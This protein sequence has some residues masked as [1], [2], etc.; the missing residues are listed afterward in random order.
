MKALVT[1]AAGF[2]GSQY[3][4]ALLSGSLPGPDDVRVTVLDKLAYS[5]NL[6]NL[7]ESRRVPATSSS[8]ATSATRA[9]STRSCLVM[10]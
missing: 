6:E 7:A 1:G 3:V 4:R 5:G 9:S 8:R 2:I 10:T